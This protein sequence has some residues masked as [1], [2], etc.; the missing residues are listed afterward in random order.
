MDFGTNCNDKKPIGDKVVSP[1][2][3]FMVSQHLEQGQ[4]RPEI[5][6]F[7]FFIFYV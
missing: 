4:I 3:S 6:H 2:Y 7:V 1:L 5:G